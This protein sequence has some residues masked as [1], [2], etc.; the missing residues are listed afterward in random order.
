MDDF[1]A[2]LDGDRIR[3]IAR[4]KVAFDKADV[5]KDGELSVPEVKEAFTGLGRDVNNETV[6]VR[7]LP[8]FTFL[9]SFPSLLLFFLVL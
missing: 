2:A 4:L 9:L 6:Q 7:L 3:L 5:N 1:L 8:F